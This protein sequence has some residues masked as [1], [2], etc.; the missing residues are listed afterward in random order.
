LLSFR[1]FTWRWRR[2]AIATVA[3]GSVLGLAL[4][5]SG[6][7][8]GFDNEI[9]RTLRAFGAGAWLVSS[10]SSGPFTAA[11]V[12]PASRVSAVRATAGVR[13][14][15]PVAIVAATAALPGPREVNLVG[16]VP[17]GVGSPSGAAASVLAAG[18][19]VA[20]SSLGVHVGQR[21]TL[22][23][24]QFR[25]GALTHGLTYFAGTPTVRVSLAQAQRLAFNGQPLASAVLTRGTPRSAP[26]GLALRS[27]AQVGA[28]LARPVAQARRTITLI[29]SLLWL[30]AA[31]I[32]GAILYLT[33]LDRLSDFAVLKAI[34]VATR[35]LL[36]GLAFQAAA[37]SLV[38]ALLAAAF[39]AAIAPQA[40]IPVEVPL[41]SYLTL[42]VVAIL[43]AILGSLLAVRRAIAVDPASA[44]GSQG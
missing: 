35:G 22:N 5:L 18:Q 37:L 40:G 16:V 39:A 24:Q 8:A 44:F 1:D 7:K 31:G 41:G 33:T 43:V 14:A 11:A 32:I 42:L 10:G 17:G 9:H 34:G 19:A 27:N 12:F 30:V 38:S 29:R 2:Y 36:L 6:I 28:D 15:D 13:S 23:G 25:V 20:D 26:P 3:S 4:L 21:F